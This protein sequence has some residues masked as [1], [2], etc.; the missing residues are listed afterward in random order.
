[1]GESTSPEH[2]KELTL[3]NELVLDYLGI[4]RPGTGKHIQTIQDELL[5]AFM[6][7]AR[8]SWLVSSPYQPPRSSNNTKDP[9]LSLLLG[10]TEINAGKIEMLSEILEDLGVHAL[11]DALANSPQAAN[12]SQIKLDPYEA[13]L[14]QAVGHPN[15]NDAVLKY[16]FLAAQ[17]PSLLSSLDEILKKAGQASLEAHHNINVIN[18]DITL[19]PP[20][21]PMPATKK[22]NRR[23]LFTG[24]GT[25]FSGLV[26][27]AGN[28]III[29]LI[30]MASVTA[31][32]VVGSLAAGIAATGKG[33][34][35]LLGE[36]EEQPPAVTVSP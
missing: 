5:P 12:L 23:K 6:E 18:V 21:S 16:L 15:P 20:G 31:I 33:I 25:L 19:P 4:P 14:L 3:L 17:N 32:P 27:V 35:E 36:G 30:P 9:I 1:M 10:P 28:S 22:P 2:E 11:M 13:R 8:Y 29:P 7:T 26:L 34:G 24:L